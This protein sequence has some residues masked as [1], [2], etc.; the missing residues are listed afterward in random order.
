[1]AS[2]KTSGSSSGTSARP[3]IC[4]PPRTRPG[5]LVNSA[6]VPPPPWPGEAP[7]SGDGRCYE[8]GKGKPPTHSQFKKGQSGNPNGR[9]KEARGLKTLVREN[10]LTKV[11]VRIAGKTKRITRIEAVIHKQLEQALKGDQRAATQLMNRYDTA[12]PDDVD[13]EGGNTA[14]ALSAGEQQILDYLLGNA[15]TSGEATDEA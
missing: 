15:G 4:P 8:V 5:T 11:P 14:D 10:L 6:A 2:R 12:V 1:M 13:R 9:P 7:P 3:A